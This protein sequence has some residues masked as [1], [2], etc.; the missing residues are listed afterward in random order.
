MFALAM[1]LSAVL[2]TTFAP[3]WVPRR[4]P[5]VGVVSVGPLPGFFPASIA[6]YVGAV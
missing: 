2:L 3:G 6:R 5:R 4:Q 1:C